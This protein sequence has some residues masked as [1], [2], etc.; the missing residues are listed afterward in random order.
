MNWQKL[1]FWGVLVGVIVYAV[2]QANASLTAK[3]NG[4]SSSGA[5]AATA[6]A[7]AGTG[8]QSSGGNS[9]SGE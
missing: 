6:S 3:L 2:K 8:T 9:T 5:G 1:L 4:Q 7:G